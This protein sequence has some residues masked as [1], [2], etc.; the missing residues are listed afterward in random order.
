MDVVLLI[1]RILFGALFLAAAAGHLTQTNALAAT[2]PRAVSH[3]QR[4]RPW[5]PECRSSS[6]A[7]R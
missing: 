5:S 4:R 6:A 3:S 7:C 2:P 1:G